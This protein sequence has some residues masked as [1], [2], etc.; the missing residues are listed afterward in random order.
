MSIVRTPCVG[1]KPN[2]DQRRKRAKAGH[3]RQTKMEKQAALGCLHMK[4]SGLCT[5]RLSHLYYRCS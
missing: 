3:L 2:D 5:S 1:R 4:D